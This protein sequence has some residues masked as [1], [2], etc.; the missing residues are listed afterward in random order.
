MCCVDPQAIV[1]T[2]REIALERG[3]NVVMPILTPTKWVVLAAQ[4]LHGCARFT[5]VTA[6]TL[7]PVAT[8]LDAASPAISQS[9]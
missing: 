9:L 4:M 6:H 2:G 5:R 3:A 7:L 8:S 1:P